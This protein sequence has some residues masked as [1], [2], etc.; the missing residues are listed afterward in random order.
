MSASAASRRTRPSVARSRASPRATTTSRTACSAPTRPAA[1]SWCARGGRSA[2]AVR[3]PEDA[4]SPSTCRATAPRPVRGH[5]ARRMLPRY[6]LEVAHRDGDQLARRPVRVPAHA[7]RARPP[8]A[9]RGPP[10]GAVGAARRAPCARSTAS[11]ARA[12]AVWAP[13]ARSRQ[14]RRRLQRLG[15]PPAP[16]ALARAARASGSCSCRASAPGARYKFE[17]RDA[18]GAARARRPTRSRSPPSCRPATASIVPTSHYVWGDGAWI[19]ARRRDRPHASR[20]R[21]TRSTSARGGAS[22]SRA[23]ARSPTASWPTELADYV[24]DLGFTHV[25]LLPVTE[26]PFDGSWGYQVDG[27][28]AP[29][30]PARHARRLPLLRR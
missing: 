24:A 29:T 1:A 13:N 28:F 23:T 8:P 9:R 5:P 17:I 3:V 27:Y 10:R 12:F 25:E 7:R 2:E 4:A 19:D 18:D 16:H 14:R 6:E 20:S 30:S 22:P 11:P 21:S 15:R 26:H